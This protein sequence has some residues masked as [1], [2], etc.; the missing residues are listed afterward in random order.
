MNGPAL[1]YWRIACP[2]GT[3]SLI[4]AAG[5]FPSNYSHVRHFKRQAQKLLACPPSC[6]VWP[7]LSKA[8]GTIMKRRLIML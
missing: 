5:V 1:P 3:P 4:A 8:G 2:I 7:P 6:S